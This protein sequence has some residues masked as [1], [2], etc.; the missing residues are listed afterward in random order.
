MV[1]G[2]FSARSDAQAEAVRRLVW[3]AGHVRSYGSAALDLAW[4]AAGRWDAVYHGR[5]PSPWDI[6]AG[7]LLCQEAGLRGERVTEDG[8][9]EPRLVVAPPG[10]IDQ[11]LAALTAA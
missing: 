10:L 6:A 7:G 3:R 4:A 2:E 5:F 11:L 8:S 1:G 9:G